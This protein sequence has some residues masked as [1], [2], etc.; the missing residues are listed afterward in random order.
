MLILVIRYSSIENILNLHPTLSI[1][2]TFNGAG[3]HS[4]WGW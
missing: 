4:G 3:V 1:E 2:N